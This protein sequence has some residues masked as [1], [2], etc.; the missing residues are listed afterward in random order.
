VY[1][2]A[3]FHIGCGKEPE[4]RDERM[5]LSAELFLWMI[6]LAFIVGGVCRCMYLVV[7]HDSIKYDLEYVW[8]NRF[9]PE[10]LDLD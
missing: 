3:S 8:D 5:A 4:E 10:E 2:F 1:L 9:A 6:V 7:T